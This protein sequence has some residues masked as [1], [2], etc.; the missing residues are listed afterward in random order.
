LWK[1]LTEYVP[2][3]KNEIL[4]RDGKLVIR[5]DSGDPVNILCGD[6]EA[7]PFSPQWVGVLGLLEEALG[8]EEDEGYAL[9]NKVAAIYG[10]SITPERA[11]EILRRTVEEHELSPYNVVLGIGSFTYEYVT[12]DTYGFAMKATAY[13]NEDNIVIPIFKNPV[14]D[15]GLKKSCKGIPVVYRTEES[16]EDNPDYFLVESKDPEQL[17]N[18]AFEKVFSNGVPLVFHKF[19]DIRK[20]A[21]V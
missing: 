7:T 12:R 14:T 10:D 19:D 1:V 13:A 21:R 5:P 2:A 6:P 11:D 18:C 15:S 16:T 3:L 17:D 4:A 9:L 8:V 20:R